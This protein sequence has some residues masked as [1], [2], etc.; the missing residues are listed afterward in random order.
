MVKCFAAR[1]RQLLLML[2][3]MFVLPA[4]GQIFDVRVYHAN[5]PTYRSLSPTKAFELHERRKQ[6]EYEERIVNVDHG[7]FCPLVFSMSG[8]VGPLCSIFLKRLAG[9]VADE[10][11]IS[12]SSAMAWLRCRLS[13]ALLRSAVMCIRGSRSSHRKPIRGTVLMFQCRWRRVA[14]RRVEVT[15]TLCTAFSRYL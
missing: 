10:M 15:S 2:A 8:A 3:P 14:A 4:F 1:P 5:A 13:F 7:S 11:H 12:Y 9:M 6:L